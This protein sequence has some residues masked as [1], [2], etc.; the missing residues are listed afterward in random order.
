MLFSLILLSREYG[1]LHHHSILPARRHKKQESTAGFES[2]V[3]NK[4]IHI[5][6]CQQPVTA[7]GKAQFCTSLGS[8][9]PLLVPVELQ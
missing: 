3:S 7:T 9:Q 6:F 1:S 2:E 4:T 5:N 8:S